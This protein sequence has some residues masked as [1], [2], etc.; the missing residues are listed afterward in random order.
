MPQYILFQLYLQ[1]IQS[2]II[3]GGAYTLNSF[4]EAG[5]WDEARIFTGETYLKK[6]IKAPWITGENAQEFTIGPDKL[7]ILTNR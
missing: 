6:G 4:I 7:L 2:V 5:L 3:E 1:D